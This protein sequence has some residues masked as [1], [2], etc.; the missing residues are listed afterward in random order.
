[1]GDCIFKHR[2]MSR[3]YKPPD[4]CPPD[5]HHSPS[6]P[7]HWR[8]IGQSRTSFSLRK[9]SGRAMNQEEGSMETQTCSACHTSSAPQNFNLFNF[10][11]K[12][13][14]RFCWK[15]VW[16]RQKINPSIMAVTS[17][18]FAVS[19]SDADSASMLFHFPFLTVIFYW[20]LIN[21]SQTRLSE[22][23]HDHSLIKSHIVT[24]EFNFGSFDEY[25]QMEEGK[26]KKKRS[27]SS[28]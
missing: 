6:S 4:A 27:F 18:C 16:R 1:M 25:R 26:K 17:R 13:F 28:M 24:R 8:R 20:D 10:N 14:S 23:G 12:S 21:H 9:L 3:F 22:S 5:C 11:Y 2:Q 19:S 15:C 7:R